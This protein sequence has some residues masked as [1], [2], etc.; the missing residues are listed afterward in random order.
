M[1]RARREFDLACIDART[2]GRGGSRRLDMLVCHTERRCHLSRGTSRKIST[3]IH[4]KSLY[5]RPNTHLSSRD[6][7]RAHLAGSLEVARPR[8][9]DDGVDPAD[10]DGASRRCDART[11]LSLRV[12]RVN[13][14]AFPCR[15]RR[16]AAEETPPRH[17]PPPQAQPEAERSPLL[18]TKNGA[19]TSSRRAILVAL[20]AVSALLFVCACV[21]LSSTARDAG[22][23][24]STSATLARTT[25]VEFAPRRPHAKAHLGVPADVAFQ[26]NFHTPVLVIGI[27][28]EEDKRRSQYVREWLA[29][30]SRLDSDILDRHVKI[31]PGVNAYNW[32]NKIEDALYGVKR[33]EELLES[34]PENERN[35]GSLYYVSALE[36]ARSAANGRLPEGF[37]GIAH[38]VGCMFAHLHQ[39]QHA[40]DKGWQDVIIFESDAPWNLGVPAFALQD[41]IDHQPSDYDVIVLTHGDTDSGEYVYSFDSHGPE[42]DSRINM[43]RWNELQGVAGLQGYVVS[44][45]FIDKLHRYVAGHGLDMV[46]AWLL[47][48]KCSGREPDT[49]RFAFNCYHATPHLFRNSPVAIREPD[50]VEGGRSY[51]RMS[52]TTFN[53]YPEFVE[54]DVVYPDQIASA[55]HPGATVEQPQ[56]ETTQQVAAMGVK[57]IAT[58]DADVDE[59]ENDVDDAANVPTEFPAGEASIPEAAPEYL[60]ESAAYETDETDETDGPSPAPE[61]SPVYAEE[62]VESSADVAAEDAA[63]PADA[64]ESADATGPEGSATEVSTA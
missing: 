41:I 19:R 23:V 50:V 39:W 60:A 42:Y 32:P 15:A 55:S 40:W 43:Y 13:P 58:E 34:D 27:D 61:S 54:Y 4:T 63:G 25:S 56:K 64:T 37:F 59:A 20:G 29:T 9:G 38:H 21:G 14:R 17:D 10:D 7:A 5:S 33:I 49:G 53:S 6:S 8:D 51:V 1:E 44:R 62:M 47:L 35:I 12:S 52:A 3:S 26:P 48:H 24:P 18:V 36:S 46:D 57:V 45:R 28:T 16:I 2:S 22:N 30:E 11:R 31:S